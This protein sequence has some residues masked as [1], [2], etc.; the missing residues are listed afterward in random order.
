MHIEDE[1]AQRIENVLAAVGFQILNLVRMRADHEIRSVIY[2]R[3]SE[4]SLPLVESAALVS[5]INEFSSRVHCHNDEIGLRFQ[6]R[7]SSLQIIK[8]LYASYVIMARD[9][10]IVKRGV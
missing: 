9:S 5:L 2:R 1:V 4:I 7:N 6:L 10:A 3:V 8:I